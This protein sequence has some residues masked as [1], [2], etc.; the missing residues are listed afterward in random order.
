MN[1]IASK[2]EDWYSSTS[3]ISC[4]PL[5]IWS[6]EGKYPGCGFTR[7]IGD[8]VAHQLGVIPSPEIVELS[9]QDS[10]QF[11]I[12]VSDGITEYLN[13]T[14][15]I[16]IVSQNSDP[17]TSANMLIEEASPRWQAN[18]DCVDDLS[19]TVIFL[20]NTPVPSPS[21]VPS[22]AMSNDDLDWNA[23][24]LTVI[25]ALASGFLG[26]LCGMGGVPI[27]FYML[28]PPSSVKFTKK[29]QVATSASITLTNVIIRVIYYLV[30]S[31]I[32]TGE[33][34][35]KVNDWLLYF[36]VILVSLF[37]VLLG[38]EISNRIQNAKQA[39]QMI[40]SLFLLIGG[41]SLLLSSFGKT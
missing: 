29:S 31:F 36:S 13:P 17:M 38:S 37:G 28:Y 40:L 20:N 12:L 19:V 33:T 5:R 7:S 23:R 27:I 2:K 11:L 8:K 1:E 3:S 10:N 35:F 25:A 14:E 21:K 6:S 26:G 30:G 39:V 18:S 16:R 4:A 34:Y 15:S 24:M 9:L 22:S 32:G 41:I